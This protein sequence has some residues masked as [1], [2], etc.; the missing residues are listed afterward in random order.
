MELYCHSRHW[1]IELIESYEGLVKILK[2]Q[3]DHVGITLAQWLGLLY[4]RRFKR[5][6]FI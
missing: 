2:F 1:K 4:S 3:T 5:R 6:K